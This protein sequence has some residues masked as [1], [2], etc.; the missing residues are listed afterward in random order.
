MVA[1]KAQN[2]IAKLKNDLGLSNDEL[3]AIAYFIETTVKKPASK[4][5]RYFKKK[6]TKLARSIEYCPEGPHIF[7]HLKTHGIDMIGRGKSKTVTYSIRYDSITPELVANCVIRDTPKAS[8]KRSI[9]N[10]TYAAKHLNNLPGICKTYAITHHAKPDGSKPQVS[11]IQK[12]YSGGTLKSYFDLH[13]TVPTASLILLTLDYLCGL[14]SIHAHDRY[15][16]DLHLSNLMIDRDTPPFRGV[17]IDFGRCMDCTEA[18]LFLPVIQAVRQ[19]NPPEVFSTRAK[20]IDPK[21]VDIY[22]LG[23]CLYRIYFQQEPEWA[24]SKARFLSTASMNEQELAAFGDLLSSQ[25]TQSI[26]KHRQSAGSNDPFA[27]MIFMMID[28]DPIKRGSID[29]VYELCYSFLSH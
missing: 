3:Y 16:G 23:L 18:S 25:I 17:L 4:K 5:Y 1:K 6:E 8:R 21:A 22:A 11:F 19:N 10:E 24:R 2:N 7:I 9:A 12:L 13:K 14:K 28:P 27:E 29:E 26:A 20:D 15:H